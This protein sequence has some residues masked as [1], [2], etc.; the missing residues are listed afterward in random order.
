MLQECN[1]GQYE[2]IYTVGLCSKRVDHQTH[3]D[4]SVKGFSKFFHW[5]IQQ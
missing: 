4:N 5:L 2:I 3:G 1:Y